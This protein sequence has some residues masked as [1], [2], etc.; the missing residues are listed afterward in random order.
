MEHLPACFKTA[1]CNS[2]RCVCKGFFSIDT[3][4]GKTSP[5][6]SKCTATVMSV[7]P[8]WTSEYVYFDQILFW[9]SDISA[10]H[11]GRFMP[12]WMTRPMLQKDYNSCHS[13]GISYNWQSA[14]RMIWIFRNF[15]QWQFWVKFLIYRKAL[16]SMPGQKCFSEKITWSDPGIYAHGNEIWQKKLILYPNG[17]NEPNLSDP[18]SLSFIE[19]MCLWLKNVR[20]RK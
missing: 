19:C 5:F 16:F 11:S 13:D 3:C 10:R 14:T 9:L 17:V 1:A 8:T 2:I 4:M 15:F 20:L 6:T 7:Q 12:A 18:V